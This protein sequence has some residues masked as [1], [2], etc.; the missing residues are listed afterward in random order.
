MD[1]KDIYHSLAEDKIQ[2]TFNVESLHGGAE[3]SND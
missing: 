3:F 2:W 1:H